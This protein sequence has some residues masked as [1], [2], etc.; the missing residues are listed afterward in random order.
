MLGGNG[1][2]DVQLLPT[3]GGF[4][5]IAVNE[6]SNVLTTTVDI[7]GKFVHSRN[8]IMDGELTPSQFYSKCDYKLFIKTFA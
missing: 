1:I 5:F 8:T 7:Y 3:V 6:R 2:T 4:T